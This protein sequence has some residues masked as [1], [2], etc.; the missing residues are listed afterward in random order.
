MAEG[1]LPQ[2]KN[3]P[4]TIRRAD[5]DQPDRR[6]QSSP[7]IPGIT[8]RREASIPLK[9]DFSNLDTVNLV[10][11]R[12]ALK[13][14]RKDQVLAESL[15]AL[16]QIAGKGTGVTPETLPS[17]LAQSGPECQTYALLNGIQA[18]EGK[19]RVQDVIPRIPEIRQRSVAAS[20]GDLEAAYEMHRVQE[21]LKEMGLLKSLGEPNN[22][23]TAARAL[24]TDHRFIGVS[25][26]TLWHA[27]TILPI[28]PA[29][30]QPGQ[31]FALLVDSLGGTTTPLSARGFL[32]VL[33]SK[34]LNETQ[35]IYEANKE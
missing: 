5:P 19:G 28:S 12:Q 20:H 22:P 1:E 4:F 10:A 9:A 25:D 2:G 13:S 32:D 16:R 30:H 18:W 6:G 21:V 11:F 27:Y 8:L 7:G 24:F 3:F 34:Q 14:S 35:I 26:P 17:A 33:T 23:I 29:F 31:D 15:S